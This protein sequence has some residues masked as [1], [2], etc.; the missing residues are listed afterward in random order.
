MTAV[1]EQ[2]QQDLMNALMLQGQAGMVYLA[3]ATAKQTADTNYDAAYA[4]FQASNALVTQKQAALD[5]CLQGQGVPSPAP[6][7]KGAA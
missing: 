5:A 2:Q 4:N 7:K 3:A 1:C 6:K